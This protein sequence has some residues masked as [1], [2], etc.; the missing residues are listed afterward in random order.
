LP[1]THRWAQDLGAIFVETGHWLRA[2]W[3][4]RT[5]E[6][7]WLDSV[8]REVQSVRASV[9]VCDVSTLGRIDL[10]GAGSAEFLDRLYTNTMTTLP[11][12][13]A[14]YGLMLRED[15][16]VFDDGTVSR[17]ADEH[18]LITTTTANAARVLQHMEYCQQ[19]LWPDLDVHV[20]SV[21]EQWAQLSLRGRDP[22][23]C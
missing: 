13:R 12:G 4:P 8:T 23:M 20:I 5:G 16:F 11:V 19:W 1:P 3:Y 22:G 10:Q 21:S 17:L 6:A 7:D 14:R 2:Q 9:G 18:F 15:G